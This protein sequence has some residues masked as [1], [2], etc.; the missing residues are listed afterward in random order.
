MLPPF[1]TGILLLLESKRLDF[2]R[3][4]TINQTTGNV[5][6]HTGDLPIW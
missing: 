6:Y 4:K 3:E 1:A 2:I 5:V